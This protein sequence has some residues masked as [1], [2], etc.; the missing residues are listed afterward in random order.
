MNT[1]FGEALRRART[2]KGISQQQLA[3]QLF[4]DRSSVANWEADRRL[5]DAK[6]IARLAEALDTDSAA[7]LHAAE[8]SSEK[9]VVIM[10]DDEKI[11]LSGGIPIL[12]QVMPNTEIV[13]FTKPSD[14]I[15]FAKQ[16]HI[17]VAFL[18]IEM[19]RISGLSL[20]EELLKINPRTN[21]IYLTAYVDYSFDAWQ[22]GACGFMKKPLTAPDVRARLKLLR[23]PVRGLV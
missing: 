5:P 20:C 8:S 16:N 10:V 9:P 23:Y 15:E 19:G 17:S 13:G 14:A 18:D 6:M 21:V 2:K 22:T 11:I 1:T 12:K 7:L 4:V 3:Q